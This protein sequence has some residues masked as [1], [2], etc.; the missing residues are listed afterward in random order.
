[1]ISNDLAHARKWLK[2]I[3]DIVTKVIK[4][5]KFALT[6][7]V[8]ILFFIIVAIFAPL[9]APYD[10]N[11]KIFIDGKLMSNQGMSPQFILGTTDMGRDIFSQLIYATR[12]ALIVGSLAGF[13]VASIGTIIGVVAGFFGGP[14]DELVMRITDIAFGIPFLPFILILVA[15]FGPSVWNTVLAIT[16]LLWRDSARPVRSQVL[17]LREKPFVEVAQASGAGSIRILFV[18]IIPNILPI[19]ILYATLGMGWAILTEASVSFIGLGDPRAVSW[20][21]MLH[22][23]YISQ[24]MLR[25]AFNW[26]IPP[27]VCIML[28]VFAVFS[29]GKGYEKFLQPRLREH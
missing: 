11:E 29:L 20:G 17:V 12:T 24:A 6:G 1:M 25:G 15:I 10:P 7:S 2:E 9:I 3:I 22:E 26:I 4:A 18:H 16:L 14:I 21:L 8:I 5:D 28:L 19:S 27:G 13:A 23:A